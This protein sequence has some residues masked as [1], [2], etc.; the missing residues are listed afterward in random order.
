MAEDNEDTGLI[1][2]SECN[3]ECTCEQKCQINKRVKETILLEDTTL[4]C[5]V[6][7]DVPEFGS[8]VNS[9]MERIL[10]RNTLVMIDARVSNDQEQASDYE[11]LSLSEEHRT[12]ENVEF[13]EM[14]QSDRIC[15][16]NLLNRCKKP[17]GKQVKTSLSY[18][19]TS[20]TE[21]E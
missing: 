1:A 14:L 16:I 10:D 12:V 20:W 15:I 21:C 9:E 8:S 7:E 17:S 3:E 4:G 13:V 5:W 18:I 2:T 6:Y 11:C 19:S